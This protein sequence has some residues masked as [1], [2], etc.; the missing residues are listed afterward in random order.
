MS[1]KM[2]WITTEENDNNKTVRIMMYC[3]DFKSNWPINIS[4]SQI[5]VSPTKQ[6]VI[7]GWLEIKKELKIAELNIEISCKCF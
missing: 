6:A 4:E 1:E 7:K 5:K 3:S 2:L